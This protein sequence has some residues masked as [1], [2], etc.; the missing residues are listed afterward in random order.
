MWFFKAPA[1]VVSLLALTLLPSTSAKIDP[2]PTI[3]ARLD[4]SRRLHMAL[5]K[6]QCENPCGTDCCASG[7]QCYWDSEGLPSCKGAQASSGWLYS[8]SY[9]T[10]AAIITKTSVWSSYVGGTTETGKSCSDSQQACG[11]TCCDSGSYCVAAGTCKL[12]G[13]GSG[14]PGVTGTVSMSAA[15]RPTSNGVTVITATATGSATATVPFTTPIP[16]GANGTLVES[17]TGGG[18]LSGG[19]IAGIVIGVIAGI[20]LLLL[21][22]F[23]CCAKALFDSVLAIFGLGKRKNKH[24]HEEATYIEEHHSGAAGGGRRWYGQGGSSRPS[25]PPKKEGGGLGKL[26]GIGA[27][28]AAVG[29]LL[30]MRKWST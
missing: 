21:I 13:G 26:L 30:G 7:Q 24:T 1:A 19:A 25:R 8:T 20:I 27:G 6:R 15:D 10:E 4:D 29:A 5:A 9:Y 12:L 18:G 11:S 3:A 17:N 22:C 2:S 28:A 23:Y 14:S 16:T